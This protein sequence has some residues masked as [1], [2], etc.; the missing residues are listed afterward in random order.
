[1]GHSAFMNMTEVSQEDKIAFFKRYM[2]TEQGMNFRKDPMLFEGLLSV[3]DLKSLEAIDFLAEVVAKGAWITRH[4]MQSFA[5]KYFGAEPEELRFFEAFFNLIPVEKLM[6]AEKAVKV[7]LK[8]F[9][10]LTDEGEDSLM[11]KYGARANTLLKI[12]NQRRN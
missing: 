9:G 12:I 2:E 6:L 1:M 3:L 11:A 10:E 4:S 7:S 8:N 5:L